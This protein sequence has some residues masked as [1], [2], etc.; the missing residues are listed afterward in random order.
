MG[1]KNWKLLYLEEKH[2]NKEIKKEY[3]KLVEEMKRIKN[4]E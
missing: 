4:A 1:E 3:N 2:K